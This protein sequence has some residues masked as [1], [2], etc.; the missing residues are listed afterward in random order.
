MTTVIQCD[1]V[2]TAFVE[3]MWKLKT[4]GV[5]EDS[6]NGRVVV[7]P[8]PVVTEYRRPMER[9][10]FHADRDANP[11]FH[12][13]ESI[14]M[15]AG[16][17]HMEFLLPFNSG[18]ARY[19]EED[20][21]MHGAYGH[22]WRTHWDRDQLAAIVEELTRDPGSRQAVL[23][24]WDPVADLNFPQYKD[25]PCNTHAYFDLR[26]G[27]LSMTVC[28]RSNDA[29]WGAYGANVVHFSVLQEWLA[30]ALGAPVGIYRQVSNNFH[31]YIYNDQCHRLLDTVE[32]IAYDPY[33]SGAASALPMVYDAQEFL[34]DCEKLV[35]AEEPN[36]QDYHTPF[37]KAVALPLYNA[38]LDRKQ[39][40]PVAWDTIEDCDWKLAFQGWVARRDTPKEIGDE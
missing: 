23:A 37:F 6:R 29:V 19:A 2:N 20:G 40:E 10:L 7:M 11:V 22:R 16:A 13:M 34:K 25:R 38:Y 17:N 39:G 12:L 26:G 8:G 1:N 24:M 21:T 4:M 18:M 33:R 27:H 5:I 14:W 36:E 3:G 35:Y 28:C 9:V 30:A 32:A 15:L 31:L